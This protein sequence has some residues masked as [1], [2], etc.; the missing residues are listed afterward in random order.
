MECHEIPKDPA[1][2]LLSSEDFSRLNETAPRLMRA[3]A[4]RAGKSVSNLRKMADEGRLTSAALLYGVNMKPHGAAAM[5]AEQ[6]QSQ[7]G[8]AAASAAA[9]IASAGVARAAATCACTRK[10]CPACD[11]HAKEHAGEAIVPKACTISIGGAAGGG[12]G[13]CGGGQP[14]SSDPW[15]EALAL[16]R[17]IVRL[18]TQMARLLDRWDSDGLPS[19]SNPL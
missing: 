3:L 2:E 10:G 17:E 5:N 9:A 15:S 18:N 19:S 13:G 16:G 7:A 6:A 11:M 12:G 1:S 8:S 4:D 14:P